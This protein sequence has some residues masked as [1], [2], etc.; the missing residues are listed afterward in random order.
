MP[1]LSL[2]VGKL[3]VTFIRVPI[4][5]LRNYRAMKKPSGKLTGSWLAVADT[6]RTASAD[7]DEYKVNA[8]KELLAVA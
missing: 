7:Y 3:P 6:L 1:L 5:Y 2:I 4:L 8:I